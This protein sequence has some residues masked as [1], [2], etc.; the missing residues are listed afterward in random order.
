MHS[1]E[2]NGIL[3]L[4]DLRLPSKEQLDKGVAI[5]ECVQEIP[6]NPCVDSC[7]VKAV[8]M[9]DINAVPVVDFDKCIG[10]GKCIGICPGLAIFVVKT[11]DDKAIIS[12]PY[13]FLP[14]PI[15]GI[16]VKALDREGKNIGD[17]EVKKI[18]KKGK[19]MII[20]IE[21]EKDLAMIIRNIRVEL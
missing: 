17:A 18:V 11:K 9:K 1:Y 8:S 5:I 15:V 2:K 14:E 16:K 21:V 10:C 12:L 6:C 4:E 20:T 19:T 3:S 13:E 7:P